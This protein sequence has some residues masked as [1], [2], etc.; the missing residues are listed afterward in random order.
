M[1]NNT[2]YATIY[3]NTN[4]LF[5]FTPNHPNY[6]SHYHVDVIDKNKEIKFNIEYG[7]SNYIPTGTGL[8]IVPGNEGEIG[9]YGPLIIYNKNNVVVKYDSIIYARELKAPK[10]NDFFY[11]ACLF[12][13]HIPKIV[14]FDSNGKIDWTRNVNNVYIIHKKNNNLIDRY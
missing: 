14:K 9:Y 4:E 12:K 10:N 8:Y 6:P 2:R 1:D 3:R 11:L 13:G 7:N 5:L